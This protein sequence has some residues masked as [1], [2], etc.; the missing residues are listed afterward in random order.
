MSL[1]L[2]SECGA[3]VSRRAA[4]CPSCGSPVESARSA[5]IKDW[6]LIL[7]IVAVV[8]GSCWIFVEM[9]IG[10]AEA[11]RLF[12]KVFHARSDLTDETVTV[13]KDEFR[14][15]LVS[16]PY[17]GKVTLEIVSLGGQSVDVHLIE[18]TD[19]LRLA[20]K[21]PPF[22]ALKLSHD[23]AF[24]ALAAQ[25]ATRSDYLTS[26]TYVVV[27]EHPKRGAPA[28]EVRVVARLAP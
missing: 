20:N 3:K 11:R 23:P 22:A 14:G 13:P 21:K 27:L 25:T 24:E 15:V 26:G 4:A 19:L 28:S 17:S 10:R 9:T 1:V 5:W 7:F 16:V 12:D 18:G 6:A 2:C 8:V